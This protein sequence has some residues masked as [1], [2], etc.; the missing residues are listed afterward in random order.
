MWLN[1]LA[2]KY[3]YNLSCLYGRWKCYDNFHPKTKLILFVLLEIN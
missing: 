3:Y 1:V 2:V